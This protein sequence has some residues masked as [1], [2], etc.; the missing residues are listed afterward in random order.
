VAYQDARNKAAVVQRP[1][2]DHEIVRARQADKSLWHCWWWMCGVGVAEMRNLRTSKSQITISHTNLDVL[3]FTFFKKIARCTAQKNHA[4]FC[5]QG[6]TKVRTYCRSRALFSLICLHEWSW[7]RFKNISL[8]IYSLELKEKLRV[9]SEYARSAL[10]LLTPFRQRNDKME[11]R[12]P[13]PWI[14][15]G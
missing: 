4:C 7:T 3:N 11:Q 8:W 10:R 1:E 12:K 5:S 15:S 2:L 13:K 9:M 14:G 6:I